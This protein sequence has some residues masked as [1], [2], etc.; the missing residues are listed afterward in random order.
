MHIRRTKLRLDIVHFV[1]IVTAHTIYRVDF[2]GIVPLCLE[3]QC[4]CSGAMATSSF[5]FST[6]LSEFTWY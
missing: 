6:S 4:C 5:V 2:G 3:S 1:T